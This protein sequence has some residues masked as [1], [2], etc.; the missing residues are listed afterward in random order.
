MHHNV[1]QKMLYNNGRGIILPDL[2]EPLYRTQYLPRKFK[3]GVTVPGDNSLD[4]Y[5][6]HRRGCDH[7]GG[8]RDHDVRAN[9][10]MKYLS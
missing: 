10:R 5:Q 2:T 8:R 6:Q 1:N 4:I 9:A 3:I 7:G